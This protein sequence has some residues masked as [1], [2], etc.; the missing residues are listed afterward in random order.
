MTP[1]TF[2][3]GKRVLVMGLGLLGGGLGTTAWLVKHGAKVTV[4]DLRSRGALRPSL[5]K[6][7]VRVGKIRL[8]LGTHRVRNF[9]ECDLLVVNPDVPEGNRYVKIAQKHAIPIE[10]EASLFF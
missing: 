9:K 6:L 2:L 1:E 8:V 10:N 7:G 5:E 4:T 3:K